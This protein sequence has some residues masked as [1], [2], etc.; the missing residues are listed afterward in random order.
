MKEINL[1][2]KSYLAPIILFAYKRPEHVRCTLQALDQNQLADESILFVFID[3]PKNQK[4]LEKVLEVRKEIRDFKTKSRFREIF[5]FEAEK[6]K[7][8]AKSVIDGVSW[9][10]KKYGKVIVVEDDILTAPN[11][12][13]FMNSA[14]EYYKDDKRIWSI[15]GYTFADKKIMQTCKHDVFPFYRG[16]SWGWSTWKDRWELTDWTLSDYS[17]FITDKK[18]R[19]AFSRGGS[20]MLRLLDEQIQGEIDSWSIIFDYEQSKREGLTIYPRVPKAVNIGFDGSGQHCIKMDAIGNTSLQE[21]SFELS[22]I[23]IDRRLMKVCTAFFSPE[24][25]V[26]GRILIVLGSIYHMI[27]GRKRND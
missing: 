24:K 17:E 20:D 14:L 23:F 27:S 22:P 26:K 18:R 10:I 21:K 16:S 25:T 3:G 12:L 13:L 11:F 1:S 6:N 2:D 15:S 19:A 9:I 7:G 4:D 5:V 8:L